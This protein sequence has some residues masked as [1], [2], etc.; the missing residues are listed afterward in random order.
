[1]A[2]WGQS[3][4]NDVWAPIITFS[5][6]KCVTKTCLRGSCPRVRYVQLTSEQVEKTG[7]E[8]EECSILEVAVSVDAWQLHTISPRAAD[9]L[10]LYNGARRAS[11]TWGWGPRAAQV[12][13]AASE[14]S[15]ESSLPLQLATHFS[16]TMKNWFIISSS[17]SRF[18]F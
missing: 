4:R 13:A 9:L 18:G 1:M 17:G 15:R 5:A 6:N 11:G 7:R 2:N 12:C 3:K 8:R 14:R 16:F 10:P